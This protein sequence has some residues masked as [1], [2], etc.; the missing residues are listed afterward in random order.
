MCP[1]SMQAD[2]V[3]YNKSMKREPFT[4]WHSLVGMA[5]LLSVE[6]VGL[7]FLVPIG[8]GALLLFG[9]AVVG[10]VVLLFVST[11]IIEEVR[12]PL[13]MLSLLSLVVAEFVVFFA[14]QYFFLVCIDPSS[15]PTIPPNIIG[16]VLH[17]TMVFVFNP[18]YLPGTGLGRALLLVNTLA[19][20]G[21]AFFILQNVGQ[22]KK[23]TRAKKSR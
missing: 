7:L 16:Y 12:S 9:T 13:H 6:T 4:L 22:F 1:A 11:E 3:R 23:T 19:S 20:L 14:F 5:L 18:L 2:L 15:F 17:S 10:A 21:L 8:F